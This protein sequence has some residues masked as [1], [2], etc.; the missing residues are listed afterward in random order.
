MTI[1]LIKSDIQKNSSHSKQLAHEAEIREDELGAKLT[2]INSKHAD[3]ALK[4]DDQVKKVEWIENNAN[5]VKIRVTEYGKK[6]KDL[7]AS[8]KNLF[9]AKNREMEIEQ[10][11]F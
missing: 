5:S 8:Q 11:K 6:L 2:A 9:G 1:D 4:V 7:G 10:E 3:L